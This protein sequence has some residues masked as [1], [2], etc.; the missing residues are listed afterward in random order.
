VNVT[1]AIIIVHEILF[2]MSEKVHNVIMKTGNQMKLKRALLFTFIVLTAV[3]VLSISPLFMTSASA[4]VYYYTPTAESNGNV[5]Y[6]V[7]SEDTCDTISLLN[8]IPLETLRS[9][10]QLD[11]DKCRFLQVGQKLLLAT[12]PT[13][14][15]TV[16]PSPTPT[17]M[18]PTPEPIKGFGTICVYL[19]NDVN[20]NAMA[21]DSEITDT[22]LAGGAISVSSVDGSYSKTGTTIGTGEAVCFDQAPEGDYNISI[23]IP[24][25][26]NATANQNYTVYLK[27]G[28]TSTIDFSAQASSSLN[29]SSN[30]ERSG[31]VLLAVVGGLF[32]IGAIGLG[33]YVRFFLRKGS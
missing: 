5:Y 16:G 12:V 9:L 3:L 17:S 26:Y 6:V 25:G 1:I 33:L 20:G 2:Q 4:Q 24:D 7:K 15:V 8:N 30:G 11:L 21:E 13:A 22:G 14:V 31:S 10:N 27:A 28:D 19:Y 32:I 23:A 18:L 29:T